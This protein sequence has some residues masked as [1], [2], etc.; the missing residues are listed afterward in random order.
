MLRNLWPV[1]FH[2]RISSISYAML[3]AVV[4]L[5]VLVFSAYAIPRASETQTVL[6][7]GALVA[8]GGA[9]LVI[10]KPIL[11]L[12]A[13][14]PT[15]FLVPLEIGTG[16]N[17]GLNAGIILLCLLLG[18]WFVG[19]A[20]GRQRI[21][22]VRSPDLLPLLPFLIVSILSFVVGQLPWFPTAPAPLFAQIGG[23]SVYI[24]SIFATLLAAHQ[25]RDLYWLQW[26]TW[27]FLAIGS[28][29]AIL[30]ARPELSE[31]AG[32][33]V[34]RG[35]LGSLLWV[36]FFSL[37]FSQ[38][39]FNQQLWIGWRLTLALMLAIGLY[40]ILIFNF[41]AK[42]G[43]VPAV[44]CIASIC[45]F[46]WP[47]LGFFA[48]LFGLAILPAIA[49]RLIATDE[50]SYATR[51]E[52]WQI[53]LEIVKEN[54][55]LGVGPA[56]YHWYTVLFPIRG[57]YVKF[58]SHSQ[59]FDLLTQTGI[60]GLGLFFWFFWRMGRLG[61]RLRTLAPPGFA[62]AYVYGAL[63]GLVG[64]LIAGALGDW[65][66]PFVYNIGLVGMRSS[67]M[68]WLFLGGLVAL[69]QMLPKPKLASIEK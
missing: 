64:T 41:N 52:A 47:R 40:G 25:I 5:G 53:L 63:G 19:M 37:G 42:S 22:L 4:V 60:L 61:W 59:Y 7:V 35:A 18:L 45:V 57:Y 33:I 65:V 12:V 10:R 58:N 23:L 16:T 69:E 1:P 62:R 24:L 28:L 6:L 34:L 9:L 67:L 17:T 13:M 55:V 21:E 14:V 44:A 51:I 30:M 15:C 3:V 68:A 43:W 50:Y 56:N 29:Y 11:G 8:L 54:P 38:V 48:A 31:L 32:R 46:R 20:A 66:L 49:T 36:W 39:F 2:N 27:L 26:L